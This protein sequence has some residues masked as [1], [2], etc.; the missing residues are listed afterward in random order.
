MVEVPR[1]GGGGHGREVPVPAQQGILATLVRT[2]LQVQ[3][4]HLQDVCGRLLCFRCAVGAV[5]HAGDVGDH[6]LAG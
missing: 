2:L 6:V 5:H 1:E 4:L 3:L